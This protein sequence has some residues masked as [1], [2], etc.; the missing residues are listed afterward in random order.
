MK[1]WDLL[2]IKRRHQLAIHDANPIEESV[3]ASQP[4]ELDARE[5]LRLQQLIIQPGENGG[6]LTRTEFERSKFCAEEKLK[7]VHQIV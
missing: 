3:S 4:V 5:L 2:R 1:K 6:V 7:N